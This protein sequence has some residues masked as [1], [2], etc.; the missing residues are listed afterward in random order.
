MKNGQS[1]HSGNKR[2]LGV[3]A[4][5]HGWPLKNVLFAKHERTVF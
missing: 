2:I 5:A 4:N 1:K 3:D